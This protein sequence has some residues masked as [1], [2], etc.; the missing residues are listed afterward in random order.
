MSDLI[1]T[2]DKEIAALKAERDRLRARLEAHEAQEAAQGPVRI[3]VLPPETRA[4][5]PSDEELR[6]L[7]DAVIGQWPRDF[8]TSSW[9]CLGAPFLP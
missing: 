4:I 1:D 3:R 2:R 6:G 8:R 5:M 7:F 9:R